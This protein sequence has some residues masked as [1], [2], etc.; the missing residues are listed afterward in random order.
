M[1]SRALHQFSLQ[2]LDVLFRQID[3]LSRTTAAFGGSQLSGN[4]LDRFDILRQTKCF[5]ERFATC[6]SAS[7]DPILLLSYNLHIPEILMLKLNKQ[8][9]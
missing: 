6:S 3:Q 7:A 2:L 1:S 9:Q 5:M 8:I 4:F